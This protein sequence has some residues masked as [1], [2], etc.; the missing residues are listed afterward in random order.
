[1]ILKPDLLDHWMG[2][3]RVSWNNLAY[4]IVN[5]VVSDRNWK[6]DFFVSKVDLIRI[7]VELLEK[8]NFFPS[9]SKNLGF[10]SRSSLL[11]LHQHHRR[12]LFE[13]RPDKKV[14]VPMGTRY[15]PNFN[16]CQPLHAKFSAN[17]KSSTNDV[18][19]RWFKSYFPLS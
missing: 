12:L 18:F 10:T 13:G 19:D 17:V 5:F 2:K 15:R 6:I 14:C 4:S 9:I 7:V 3:N 16:S 11:S 1:M 8:R